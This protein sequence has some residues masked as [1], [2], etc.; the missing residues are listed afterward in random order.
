MSRV[1]H[2]KGKIRELPLVNGCLETTCLAV[3]QEAGRGD[4]IGSRYT[5]HEFIMDELYNEYLIMNGKLYAIESKEYDD[6]RDIAEATVNPDGT[7]DFEVK[8]Y[9]GGASMCEMIR[10]AVDKLEVTTEPYENTCVGG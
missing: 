2:H 9:N 7:I 8:F 6:N 5:A 10:L 4:E 3:I 1:E